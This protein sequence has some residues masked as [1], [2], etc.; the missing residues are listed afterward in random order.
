MTGQELTEKLDKMRFRLQLA[1]IVDQRSLILRRQDTLRGLQQRS[2]QLE[3]QLYNHERLWLSTAQ[4]KDDTSF[5]GEG[6]SKA[7][8]GSDKD[9]E[10]EVLQGKIELQRSLEDTKEQ[11]PGLV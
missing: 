6:D 8:E 5:A 7:D 11:V 9:E 1:S 2:R 4:H 10:S 3:R